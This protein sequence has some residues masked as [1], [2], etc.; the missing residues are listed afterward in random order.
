M[1]ACA[2]QN[3]LILRYLAMLRLDDNN[4]SRK[5]TFAIWLLMAFQA[6][7]VNVGGLFVSGSFVS[8][9][10]GTSSRIGMS[11]AQ[12]DFVVLMTFL[13]VLVAFMMGAG[14]AG[15]NLEVRKRLGKSRKYIRV[16]AV[17]AFFF[18]LVLLLSNN[19]ALTILNTTKDQT[20]LIIIFML[21]F[22]CGIQN[23][24]CSIATNGFLKPTHMT[25]LATDLGLGF[26][27]W[28]ENVSKEDELKKTAKK[29]CSFNFLYFWWGHFY[30]DF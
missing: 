16:A 7:Y 21:S 5:F 13:T 26:A 30:F 6:G 17:K 28:F 25:G 11:I 15:A 23:A 19:D 10:T 24:T 27:R 29:S 8:H 12:L 20:N 2:S 14:F 9:V 18:G 1:L 3:H 22:C 4:F